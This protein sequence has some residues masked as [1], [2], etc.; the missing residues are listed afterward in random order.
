MPCQGRPD[1]R[2]HGCNQGSNKGEATVGL[3]LEVA[4]PVGCRPSEYRIGAAHGQND[5]LARLRRRQ[6]PGIEEAES[7]SWTV[8]RS[9]KSHLGNLG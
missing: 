3:R 1:E 4:G 8:V 5:P 6:I 7:V 2:Q 9:G